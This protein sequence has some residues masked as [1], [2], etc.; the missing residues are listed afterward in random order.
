[1]VPEHLLADYEHININGH[2]A[3]IGTTFVE[4]RRGFY[5]CHA[6]P[7]VQCPIWLDKSSLCTPCQPSRASLF[8]K[9]SHFPKLEVFLK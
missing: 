8:K 5:L 7:T 3:C 6:V 1:M 2:K 9:I 4:M